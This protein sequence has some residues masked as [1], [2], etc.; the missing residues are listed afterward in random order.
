[1]TAKIKSHPHR[2]QQVKVRAGVGIQ[3]TL[4]SEQTGLGISTLRKHGQVVG[5][6]HLYPTSP[7]PDEDDGP[8]SNCDIGSY[9]D[10]GDS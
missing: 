9:N 7:D 10:F 8:F 5:D 1:M 3:M 6:E 2:Q 4:F